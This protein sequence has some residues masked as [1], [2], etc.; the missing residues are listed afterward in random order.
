MS[1]QLLDV[2]Q[3][4][5]DGLALSLVMIRARARVGVRARARVGVRVRVRVRWPAACS[6]PVKGWGC[7]SGWD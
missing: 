1:A 2:T 6:L 7:G 5:R 4:D 3:D